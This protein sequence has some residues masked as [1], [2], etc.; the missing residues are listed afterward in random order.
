[1]FL[2]AD[3]TTEVKPED[4]VYVLEAEYDDKTG[5]RI[6]ETYSHAVHESPGR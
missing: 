4:A 1:M 5:K 6:S 2:A 3:R